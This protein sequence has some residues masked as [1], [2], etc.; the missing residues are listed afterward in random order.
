[1]YIWFCY[2]SWFDFL[3]TEYG[4]PEKD[5]CEV[6]PTTLRSTLICK[7]PNKIANLESLDGLNFIVSSP[8][9]SVTVAV[10]IK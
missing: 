7:Y 6:K 8:F 4:P 9:Y 3:T 10:G 2:Y 1:M 5:E